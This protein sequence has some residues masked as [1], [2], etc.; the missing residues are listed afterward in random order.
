M[1]LQVGQA[2]EWELIPVVHNPCSDAPS[3][4]AVILTV[5]PRTL[6]VQ[7]LP[8]LGPLTWLLNAVALKETTREGT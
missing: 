7:E 8:H 3:P 4:T 5:T 2:S 6:E 1:K